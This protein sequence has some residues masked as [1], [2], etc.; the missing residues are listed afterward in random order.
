MN[1][2]MKIVFFGLI[3]FILSSCG[4]A[5]GLVKNTDTETKS[6]PSGILSDKGKGT[7]EGEKTLDDRLKKEKKDEFSSRK[8]DSTTEEDRESKTSKG[9][10]SKEGPIKPN[11]NP[12]DLKIPQAGEHD[13]NEEF[14]YFMSFLNNSIDNNELTPLLNEITGR[15]I[16]AVLDSSGLPLYQAKINLKDKI[17]TTYADGELLLPGD[18]ISL[19]NIQYGDLSTNVKLIKNGYQRQVI[20]L[21]TKRIDLQTLD[22]DIVFLM[23]TTG[24]MQ[25]E[26]DKL[27]DT[28][29]S[30]YQRIKKMPAKNLNIRLGMV[31]YRDQGDEYLTQEFQLTGKIDE[32]QNFLFTVNAG[33]GGDYPEDLISGLDKT[34]N[35]MNWKKKSVKMVFLVT[36]APAHVEDLSKFRDLINQAKNQNI[37]VFSIGASGLDLSGEVH[38]RVVS[39]MTKGK[40][41]FLTYGETG[42]SSGSDAPEDKGKVSH[43]TGANYN[44]R[45]LDDIVVDNVRQEIYYQLPAAELIAVHE[46]YDFKNDED[47]IF[48]RVDNAIKQLKKQLDNDSKITTNSTVLIIPLDAEDKKLLD[49]ANHIGTVS[50]NIITTDKLMRIVDRSK[51]KA[52]VDEIKLKLS[53]MTQSENFKGFTDADTILTGKIYFVGSST[54]LFIRLIDTLTSE[55]IAASMVKI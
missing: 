38:L 44:S 40:F 5:Q 14:N 11:I 16:V 47:K 42:E 10:E 24:S 52:L 23:D 50:E 19:I 31:L 55:V 36:D 48:R 26:I 8:I 54:V 4:G 35:G 9:P 27:R 41:I 33:G 45:S 43:H 3:F 6:S 13:D 37:K 15:N 34:V 28:I 22:L 51:L 25:D 30:I 12:N 2:L 7:S 1:Y 21:N 20:K 18:D 39:Q 17:S 29:Y 49:L 53:G 46:K 32:F